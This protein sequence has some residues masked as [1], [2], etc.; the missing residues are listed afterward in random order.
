MIGALLIGLCHKHT[1]SKYKFSVGINKKFK[2]TD[3]FEA[4]IGLSC[5]FRT[6]NFAQ[7]QYTCIFVR[8]KFS[9]CRMQ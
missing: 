4:L 6:L 2:G 5:L 7:Y 1:K 8:F 9:H 3:L